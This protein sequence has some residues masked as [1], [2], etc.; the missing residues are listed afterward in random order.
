VI[1]ACGSQTCRGCGGTRASA[2]GP[3]LL[4]LIYRRLTES[5]NIADFHEP[6]GALA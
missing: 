2:S 1:E 5:F 4:A 6:L 3:E